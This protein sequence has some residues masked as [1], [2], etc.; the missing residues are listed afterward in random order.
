MVVLAVDTCRFAFQGPDDVQRAKAEDDTRRAAAQSQRFKRGTKAAAL[1]I[2]GAM[3]QGHPLPAEV[4]EGV[5]TLLSRA[6]IRAAESPLWR[7][8]CTMRPPLPILFR[9]CRLV[10][11]EPEEVFG[12]VVYSGYECAG[13]FEEELHSLVSWYSVVR[14]HSGA[15]EI[16]VLQMFRLPSSVASLR[17][18]NQPG[19][20][21]KSIVPVYDR[22]N[23]VVNKEAM[24]KGVMATAE[25]R[26]L[27]ENVLH[28]IVVEGLM[29]NQCL[30]RLP[31]GTLI[32]HV[33][34]VLYIMLTLLRPPF[35]CVGVNCEM[36]QLCYVF[37]HRHIT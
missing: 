31:T 34:V 1:A 36:F 18:P 20:G 30:N 3:Y 22:G 17:R 24:P 6:G 37:A 12:T 4:A 16:G 25:I 33:I 23:T 21:G 14:G 10:Q 27:V 8:V 19:D 13:E 2:V 29:A 5:R 7:Y 32:H 28:P 11:L 9:L 15:D 35:Y 26:K